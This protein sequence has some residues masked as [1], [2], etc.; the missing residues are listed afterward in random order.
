MTN[1]H[2][3]TPHWFLAL[4]LASMSMASAETMDFSDQ[5]TPFCEVLGLKVAPPPG[6]I[7]V[8]IDTGQ[9]GDLAG[10][11]MMHIEAKALTGI[12]RILSLDIPDGSPNPE[13]P[14]WF[15]RMVSLEVPFLEA[16]GY[17]LGELLFRRDSVPIAGQ[18]FEGARALGVG[19]LIEGGDGTPQEAHF[20]LF[21]GPQA[22]YVITTLTP[23]RDVEGGSYYKKN[24][25]AMGTVMRTLVVPVADQIRSESAEP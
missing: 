2:P 1:P 16:M 13:A 4:L 17:Q 22:K 7:N 21:K 3:R 11:Q 9:R 5:I 15:Q 19:A 18:G 14:P 10:C 8:P 23:G 20:L 24:T 25:Q 12:I 6:W